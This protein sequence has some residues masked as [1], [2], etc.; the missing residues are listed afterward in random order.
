MAETIQS[1]ICIPNIGPNER[2]RRLTGGLLG[3]GVA[4]VIAVVLLAAGADRWWRLVLF[5]LFYGG[6]SGVFQ[7]REK[8]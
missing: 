1:D 7:W 3:L 8:T 6:M 4:V 2:R 5:P